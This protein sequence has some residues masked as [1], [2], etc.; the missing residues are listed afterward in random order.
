MMLSWIDQ[1]NKKNSM[2]E[3]DLSLLIPETN[4]VKNACHYIVKNFLFRVNWT[5]PRNHGKDIVEM[6]EQIKV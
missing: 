6:Y 2:F 3:Y 4:L 5:R 1:E